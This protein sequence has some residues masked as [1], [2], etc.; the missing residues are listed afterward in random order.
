MMR[1]ALV[2]AATLALSGCVEPLTND[3]I[4]RETEKCAAAGMGVTA[5]VSGLSNF[6]IQ[7]I[8]CSPHKKPTTKDRPND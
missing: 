5:Y 4:I 8:E 2:I 1:A 6:Q 7:R 3:E